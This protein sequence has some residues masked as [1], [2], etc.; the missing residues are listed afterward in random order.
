MDFFIPSALKIILVFLKNVIILDNVVVKWTL[1]IS[2]FRFCF[3]LFAITKLSEQI[4][5]DVTRQIL[6][7]TTSSAWRV[8]WCRLQ[9][10]GSVWSAFLSSTSRRRQRSAA[11]PY[12]SRA[13][14]RTNEATTYDTARTV[15]CCCGNV[16]MPCAL[17]CNTPQ[18]SFTESKR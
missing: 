6:K 7:A 4:E 14:L 1:K 11:S 3:V 9:V 5:T 16:P 17:A 13:R 18:W 2:F 8:S 10:A 15:L 12:S